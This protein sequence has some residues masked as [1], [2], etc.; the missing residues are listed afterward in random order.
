MTAE[1]GFD[2]TSNHVEGSALYIDIASYSGGASGKSAKAR[3]AQLIPVKG[4][5]EYDIY[6]WLENLAADG[7]VGGDGLDVTVEEFTANSYGTP[8][9]STSILS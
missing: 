5:T 6:L 8:V 2:N 7:I 1:V 4:S 3:N 9:Q